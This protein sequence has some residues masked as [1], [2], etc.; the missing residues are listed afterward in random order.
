[1]ASHSNKSAPQLTNIIR[2]AEWL[3]IMAASST[4][5]RL[6]DVLLEHIS[7]DIKGVSVGRLASWSREGGVVMDL[8]FTPCSCISLRAI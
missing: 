4:P 2:R 8:D 7:R 6:K 3:I 5:E 1:M